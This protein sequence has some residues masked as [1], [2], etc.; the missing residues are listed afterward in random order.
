VCLCVLVYVYMGFGGCADVVVA[1]RGWG[2][3]V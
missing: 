1:T 3:R 2:S